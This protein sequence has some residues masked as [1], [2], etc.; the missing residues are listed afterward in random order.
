MKA[1]HETLRSLLLSLLEVSESKKILLIWNANNSFISESIKSAK[2]RLHAWF[3][4]PP[5]KL[6]K[7][8]GFKKSYFEGAK[9]S[10][11]CMTG[12]ICAVMTS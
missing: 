8:H 9:K 6:L 4:F 5:E 12:M 1:D 10:S 7:S 2:W 3:F 11:P